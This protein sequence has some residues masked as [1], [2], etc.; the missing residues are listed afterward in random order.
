MHIHTA[1]KRPTPHPSKT[2]PT[3]SARAPRHLLRQAAPIIGIGLFLF[4]WQAVV[5]LR[6]YPEFIIPSPAAV[7]SRFVDVLLDGRLW[8]HTSTTALQIILGFALGA[9]L[10]IS[11]GYVVAK[12]LVFEA[13]VS[14]IFIAI[15]STPVVAYA[16][17]PNQI[18]SSG[19]ASKVI[20]SA[21]IVFFPLLLNT[22]V[23][24]RSVP[25]DQRDVMRLLNASRWQIFWQL[26]VPAA[27]PILLGGLKVS[28]TLAVIGA[29]VGEFVSAKAGLG[30]LIER[31]D[32]DFD[33]PLVFVA[34][35]ML[36]LLA[37]VMYGAVAWVERRVLRWRVK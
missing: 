11:V 20:T 22:V 4:I 13:I 14:P 3:Q 25:N 9:T 6:L 34:I 31:A 27:L 26:E 15:Q 21:L 7:A 17:L 8:L 23:G 37:R 12:S 35:V 10:A 24:V 18:T 1:L 16:P 30:Y 29:V 5:W 33:T 2:N 19:A 36:A 32:Y 28:A